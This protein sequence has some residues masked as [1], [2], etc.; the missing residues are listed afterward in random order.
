MSKTPHSSRHHHPH[1]WHSPGYVSKW[2]ERQ[3]EREIG[4]Q[5]PFRLMA[6]AIPYDKDYPIRI[7]DVGAGYGALTQFLLNHFSKATA[8]CQDSSQEMIKL[9]LKRMEALKGRFSYVCCDFGKPGWGQIVKGPFEAAV[10]SIAIHNL[11]SQS[12]IR[13]VYKEIFPLVKRGGC[14]LNFDHQNPALEDQMEWL[15]EAGFENVKCFWQDERRAL[16]G[17][18]NLEVE[19][20]ATT[21]SP[22]TR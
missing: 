10:S 14:F 5:A 4:R 1:D 11:P 15:R 17:G 21:F 16:F 22:N 13:R 6:K 2:A 8:V 19:G 18:F 12:R 20:R 3:D 9:G 7:L